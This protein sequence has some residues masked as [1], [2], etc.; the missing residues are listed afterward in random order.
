MIG[1]TISHYDVR[2]KLGEGGM[3]V[4]YKAFDSHLGRLVAVKV[5]PQD[6]VADAE[7]KH[8]FIQ[9]AKAASALNHPNIVTIYDIDLARGIDFI[10]ME[11]VSGK[12]LDKLIPRHGLRLN[13]ALNYS[14]QI[15]AALASAH[16]AG[17][18]HRDLKP[19]NVMVNEQGLVKVLDFG[20]AKLTEPTE[21]SEDE[22]R[23]LKPTTEEGKIVGTVS[24]MSPEQAEGKKVDA[25][26]DIFSFGA[27][28]YEMVTGRRAFQGDSK[29]S[30]LTAIL[31]E[32]PAPASQFVKGLPRELERVIARCLRK[33]PERRFQAM[34]DL[35]VALEE[36]KDESDSG[37]LGAIPS[38]TR[39]HRALLT[40]GMALVF[41]CLFGVLWFTRSTHKAPESTLTAV[42]FVTY[43]GSPG[44]PAFSPDGNQVAFDWEGEK[45][46]NQDIYVKLIGTAG[47]PL[48]LTSNPAGSYSPSWSPDGRF[49]AFLR[50]LS[51]ENSAVLLISAL[52]GPERKV[53][54]IAGP[55]AFSDLPSPR[56]A[57]FPDGKWLAVI[58][59]DFPTAPYALSLLSVETGE[60]RKMTSPPAQA[61]GDSAP[62]FSP[63]GHTMVF[64]RRL[65]FGV[66]D[67]YRL[68]LSGSPEGPKPMGEAKRVTFENRGA[69][70]PAWTS[71]GREIVFAEAGSIWRTD[72]PSKEAATKPR[73]LA[74]LGGNVFGLAVSSHGQ[75]L[76]YGHRIFHSSIWRTAAPF[77]DGSPSNDLGNSRK[78]LGPTSFISSTRDDSAPQ[79]SHDGK[80]IAFMSDRSGFPEIW[81]CDSDGA[82]P[83]QLTSFG[84]PEVTTPR[85]SPDGTRIA[86]D[87]NTGGQYDIWVVDAN[88]GMPHR[89]TNDP[90]NDGNPSWS[91]D[92]RWIYFDSARTG[93]QQLWKVPA[94]GGDPVQVT[95]DG[96]FAPVE[97]PDGRFLYYLKGLIDSDIWRI[98]IDSGQATKVLEGVSEYR[99][100]AVLESGLV[101]V[102]SRNISSLQ[103]LSFAS[104]KIAPLANF[105]RPIAQ[106]SLGGLGISPDRRWILYTRF[107]QT[108]NELML[109]EGFR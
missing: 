47:P 23:S 66:G 64:S 106:G 89:M 105:D 68:D 109:V 22:T 5:L 13:E 75:S 39:P 7:R 37:K 87:S 50:D 95:F 85:W 69:T 98:S 26:S 30:T 12:A 17:I 83:Q 81:S 18:V 45:K 27:L 43:P 60:K 107:E 62:A 94:N 31:R 6:K 1:Q 92:G 90:A 9:E 86:F 100:L 80:R 57:W 108:G 74:S 82:N 11:L 103:F 2:E 72:T 59:R 67:L 65:D 38:S 46:D 102:P 71:D 97:S 19:G 36:L 96:G 99:N 32:E 91:R 44:I 28:L 3:G 20:L 29:L 35:K 56:V 4:V 54:E 25:R 48:R 58:D 40:W 88:G 21:S 104:G 93:Q 10:A 8:R 15:A 70:S 34:P 41:L 73:Q 51:P 76:A 61:T 84:G 33:S 55:P 101:F 52:G 42:P 16:K 49:I 53:A 78:A 24:Y 79:Y 77:S 63:D 14:V